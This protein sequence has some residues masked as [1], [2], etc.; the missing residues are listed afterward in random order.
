MSAD[1]IVIVTNK[2]GRVADITAGIQV[3][4]KKSWIGFREAL[5]LRGKLTYAE[6][7]LFGRVTAGVCRLL[8][9]WARDGDDKCLSPEEVQLLVS[10]G[11]T[12]ECA[13]PRCIK[14]P[15]ACYPVVVFTD[16][17]CEPMGTSIGG[18]IFA[19]GRQ[20][21]A[22]GAI[23]SQEVVSSWLT[24]LGQTQVIGQAEIFPVLVARWTWAEELKNK[25]VLYFIDNDSARLALVKSYSP[26]LPSLKI[27]SE[28]SEWDCANSSC[29]WYA[30]VPTE[31]NVADGPSRMESREVVQNY[32]ARIVPPVFAGDRFVWTSDVL[33]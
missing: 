8:S 25:R 19:P 2:P 26:V 31:A 16:G 22:F 4:K 5:S 14:P 30:R 7:Q 17:A 1:K 3:I 20:P 6:G 23:L 33:S 12:L 28:C 32:G 18:V 24:K 21:M 27:I 15:S 29:A 11:D 9:Q 10:A 13:G